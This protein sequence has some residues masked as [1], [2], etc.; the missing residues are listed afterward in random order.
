MLACEAEVMVCMVGYF[1]KVLNPT[2]SD[3]NK[4]TADLTSGG[5]FVL[6]TGDLRLPAQASHIRGLHLNGTLASPPPGCRVRLRTAPDAENY[7]S[8]SAKNLKG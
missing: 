3:R 1:A 6:P 2:R 7:L 5:R 4:K 8:R